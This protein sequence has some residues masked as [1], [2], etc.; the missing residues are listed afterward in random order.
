MDTK[1]DGGENWGER[2]VCLAGG[3]TASS[4]LHNQCKVD[5]FLLRQAKCIAEAELHAMVR[6]RG[7]RN[8]RVGAMETLEIKGRLLHTVHVPGMALSISKYVS[9]VRRPERAS[10]PSGENTV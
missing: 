3:V 5:L 9:M 6:G 8:G 2:V 1:C 7:K 4:P 10:C